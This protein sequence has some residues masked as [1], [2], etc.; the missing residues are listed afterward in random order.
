MGTFRHGG[1]RQIRNLQFLLF[2]IRI[3]YF[4]NAVMHLRQEELQKGPQLG[5]FVLGRSLKPLLVRSSKT[6]TIYQFAASKRD[7]L[8]SHDVA[9]DNIHL[10]PD[11]R[12]L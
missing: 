7:S 1:P 11:G 9:N 3:F 6:N 12:V 4:D 2:C 8:V 5:D 10:Q